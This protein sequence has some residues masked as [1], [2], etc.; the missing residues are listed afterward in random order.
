MFEDARVFVTTT[1]S[2]SAPSKS[3]SSV[4]LYAIILIVILKVSKERTRF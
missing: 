1:D 2:Q 3:T 4:S